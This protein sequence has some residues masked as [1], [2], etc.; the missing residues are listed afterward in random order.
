MSALQVTEQSFA[1]DVVR[2]ARAESDLA[3]R[4]NNSTFVL[5]ALVGTGVVKSMTVVRPCQDLPRHGKK[6]LLIEFRTHERLTISFAVS[7][8]SRTGAARETE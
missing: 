2:L 1:T 6:N 4:S 7:L 8:T 3:T 5:V